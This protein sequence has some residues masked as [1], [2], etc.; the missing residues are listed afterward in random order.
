MTNIH[1]VPQSK[2]TLG[3]I[4]IT[5]AADLKLPPLDISRALMRHCLCDWGDVSDDEKAANGRALQDGLRLLSV[6]HDRNGVVF[7]VITE[8]DRSTTT[9]LLPDD[10]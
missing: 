2:F 1:N 5:P 3:G 6:Y 7:W 10:Y 8:A 4:V 9:V